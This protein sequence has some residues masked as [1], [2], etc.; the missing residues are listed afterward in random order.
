M[1]NT[2]LS[3]FITL[4]DLAV[5]RLLGGRCLNRADDVRGPD[6]N[7]STAPACHAAR[8]GAGQC[9]SGRAAGRDPPARCSA[10]GSSGWSA[11]SSTA[12]MAVRSPGDILIALVSPGDYADA[13]QRILQSGRRVR[14]HYRGR[15]LPFPLSHIDSVLSLL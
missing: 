2:P 15:A 13:G 5:A 12:S 10:G 14:G 3:Q 6:G 8:P 1:A 11:M 7:G 4:S 9:Q